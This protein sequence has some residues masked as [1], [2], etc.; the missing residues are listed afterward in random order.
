MENSR[1]NSVQKGTNAFVGGIFGSGLRIVIQLAAQ[2]ALA[3]ILGPEQYGQYA[4]CVIVIGIFLFAADSGLAYS[5][6]QEREVTNNDVSF[7]FTWQLLLGLLITLLIILSAE[8]ASWFFQKPEIASILH[9][10]SIVCFFQSI[11]V[12]SS[13]LLRKNLKI[14]HIHYSHAASYFIG[15]V[16]I[17]IPLAILNRGVWSLAAAWIIQ[18]VV[19]FC[20][21]YHFS[22]HP[23]HLKFR[24]PKAQRLVAYGGL[25]MMTNIV[26][27]AVSNVDKLIIGR[28]LPSHSIG[29]YSTASNLMTYGT[30][31]F[32]QVLQSVFF[33]LL[34][35]SPNDSE[36]A[37]KGF[38]TLL[39]ALTLFV[40]PFYAWIFASSEPLVFTLYGA[41]WLDSATV[42]APIALAMP[43]LLFLGIA[44]P[45]LW[46][47]GRARNEVYAQIPALLFGALL[48]YFSAQHSIQAVAWAVLMLFVCRFLIFL[49]QVQVAVRVT[50]RAI[51][52]SCANGAIIGIC[53]VLAIS[54]LNHLAFPIC[55]YVVTLALDAILGA[56]VMLLLLRYPSRTVSPPVRDLYVSVASRI[57]VVGEKFGRLIG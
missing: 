35:L 15:Y 14:Q 54:A 50:L 48:F 33:S 2:I 1:N 55:G 30:S 20:I 4:L 18:S 43:V 5:L 9:W 40:L 57:P 23:V 10:L 22:R 38:L 7:V 44:T 36:R 34:A 24:N 56:S 51:V 45:V 6:I 39:E 19:H 12:V 47:T 21:L 26:N 49:R 53:Q 11:S 29:I 46:N 27:W 13:S 31:A 37:R 28:M 8:P 52:D 42:M 17:G 41:A 25:V 16:A 3:R 32:Q